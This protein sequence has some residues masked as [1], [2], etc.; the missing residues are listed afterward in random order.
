MTAIIHSEFSRPKWR[1]IVLS[2]LAFWLSSS[3]I[4]D[5]IIMPSLYAAGMM[6]QPGFASAGYSIFWIFNH[7]EVVCAAL[8]LTGVLLLNNLSHAG[9]HWQVPV[10]FGLLAIALIFTYG[11]APEMSALG[12]QL[13]LFESTTKVPAGMNQMH[14]G[15]WLLE[16][17]KLALSGAL[18]GV[19]YRQSQTA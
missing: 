12:L 9:N 3:L 8:V 16:M 15:Y 4:L 5:L 6:T 18:L 1:M 11:L 7:V 10:A 14:S 2:A 19:I 13:D 17:L